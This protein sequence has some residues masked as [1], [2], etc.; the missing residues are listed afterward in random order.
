MPSPHCPRV[1]FG[2]ISGPPGRLARSVA[3]QPLMV[4]ID[5]LER[6]TEYWLRQSLRGGPVPRAPVPVPR[7][8][9]R[10]DPVV[11]VPGAVDHS[12]FPP[13]P[14][15]CVRAGLQGEGG[16]GGWGFAACDRG[17]RSA[18][19]TERLPDQVRNVGTPRAW[20]MAELVGPT[21]RSDIPDRDGVRRSLERA[22]GLQYCAEG[23]GAVGASIPIRARW[24]RHRRA[25]PESEI[26]VPL[27]DGTGQRFRSRYSWLTSGVGGSLASIVSVSCG[28][29]E[30]LASLHP[31]RRPRLLGLQAR[32]RVTARVRT[33]ET[34]PMPT[35]AGNWTANWRCRPEASIDTSVVISR[36]QPFVAALDT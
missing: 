4:S 6:Q 9:V 36:K 35:F 17:L 18:G 31:R 27:A 3:Q 2:G 1:I 7:G 15:H 16:D 22:G 14:R 23:F 24:R 5:R 10:G 19:D 26:R 30:S 25:R 32:C 12:T 11:A 29:F 13:R 28:V 20:I 33:V 8:P 21:K 34:C